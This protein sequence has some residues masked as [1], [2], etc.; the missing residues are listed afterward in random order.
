MA[1]FYQRMQNL[2]TPLLKQFKQGVITLTRNVEGPPVDPL[3]PWEPGPI[4]KTTITL[5]GVATGIKAYQIT[6][7]EIAASDLVVTCAA[8]DSSGNLI[9][10]KET[11]AM[12]INGKA[13]QIKKIQARPA[14][15]IPVVYAIFVAR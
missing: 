7:T 14:A 10:P 11:D 15:G 2:A 6:N 5:S 13:Y 3:K 8:V 12:T 1:D 4:T 9:D